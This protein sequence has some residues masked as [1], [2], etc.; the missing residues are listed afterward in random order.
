MLFLAGVG[1]F[2]DDT[3]AIWRI[4]GYI[5]L[6]FKIVIPLLLIV[7]GMVDLGKAVVSSDDKAISKAVSSLIKRFVAA[8]VL[9]F[10]PTIV[11]AIFNVINIS[12][13]ENVNSKC[14][15]CVTNVLNTQKCPVKTV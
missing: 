6:V 13:G 3:A 12:A 1:E 4:F 15:D 5:V 14:I 8:V 7:F 9:F 2:C 10:V 11:N